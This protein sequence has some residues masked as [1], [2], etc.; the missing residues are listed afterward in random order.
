MKILLDQNLQRSLMPPLRAASIDVVHTWDVEL[1]QSSDEEVFEWCCASVRMLVT[2]D[3]KL[4]KYLAASGMTC[5]TVVRSSCEI[6][7]SSL[8]KT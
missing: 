3:K 7:E 2:S 6:R 8:L 5:P 4:T 1:A